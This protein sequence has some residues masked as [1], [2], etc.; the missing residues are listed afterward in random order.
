MERME[1]KFLG[2]GTSSGIPVIACDCAVCNSSDPRN[3]RRRTSLYLVVPGAHILVDCAPDFREQALAYGLRRVDAILFTHAHADHI[4]GLDDI[5]RFNTVQDGVI[6]A[7][8]APETL[9]DIKRVFSY[10]TEEKVHGLYR[11]MVE[12]RPVEGAFSIGDVKITPFDV[13]HGSMR[14]LGFRFD[15]RGCSLGY[16]PDCHTM[17]ELAEDT[18]KGVDVIVLDCL[19]LSPRHV[20][21]LVLDQ[22][23][24]LLDRIG[25]KQS[26]LIH[27][28]HNVDHAELASQLPDGIA[29]AYDGMQLFF[30]PDGV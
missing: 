16:V 13:E 23:L 3:R 1:I 12:F 26:F 24:E 14:T 29:P 19:R 18:L 21:H 10:I 15:W 27:L 22:C 4:F 6:P 25:A 5:R 20:T 2:T 11:P 17:P 8:A 7:Y 9:V 30:E 28:C